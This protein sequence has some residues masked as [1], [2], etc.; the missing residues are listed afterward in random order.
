MNTYFAVYKRVVCIRI[1][2]RTSW[3]VPTYSKRD[4]NVCINSLA[5]I[6]TTLF[7]KK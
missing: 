5:L 3:M 1:A 2:D 7:I 6:V 4:Y